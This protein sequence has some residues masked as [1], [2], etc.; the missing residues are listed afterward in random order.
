MP[1]LKAAIE[2]RQPITARQL[3]GDL[4]DR[5]R[6]E[7]REDPPSGV[8]WPAGRGSASSCAREGEF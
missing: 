8:D 6:A 1:H 3:Y 5:M 2:S 7:L 4:I